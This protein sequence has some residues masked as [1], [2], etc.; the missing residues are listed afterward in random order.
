MQKIGNNVATANDGIE[1]LK[2]V[3][4]NPFDLILLDIIMP[5]MNGYEVLEFLKKDKRYYEIPIIM[6]SSMDDLTSIDASNWEL[7]IM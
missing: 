6:L 1:A 2:R 7:M 4:E 5:N 3:N